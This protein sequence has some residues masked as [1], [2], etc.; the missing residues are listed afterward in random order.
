MG[1]F[2][3]ALRAWDVEGNQSQV[4]LGIRHLVNAV[5]CQDQV[6][7]PHLPNSD[8]VVIYSGSNFTGSY[9]T[10]GIGNHN[11][12]QLAP[13]LTNDTASVIVGEN[14][15]LRMYDGDA[16]SDRRETLT[17]SDRNLADNPINS[18]HMSSASVQLRTIDDRV[19][20][21]FVDGSLDPHGPSSADPTA[22]D[23][24]TVAWRADG[25]TKYQTRI[26]SGSLASS[27]G[28]RQFRLLDR[29]LPGM[30]NP[31]HLVDRNIA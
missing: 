24:I 9:R 13:V 15:Q 1:P 30:V 29:P 2:N 23:S 17:N 10:L 5:D 31:T 25:A 22:V 21:L 19:L 18:D 14:V 6:Y 7:A 8:Q 20:E 28:V 16:W 27:G 3:L 11:P 26:F 4:P 12:S